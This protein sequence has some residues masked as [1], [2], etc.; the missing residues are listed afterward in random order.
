MV[1]KLYEAFMYVIK[2]ELK[3]SIR[4]YVILGAFDGILLGLSILLAGVISHIS[5]DSISISIY[6]GIVATA[7][8][9][10]W[11]ALVVELGEKKTELERMEK[12]VLKSLRGTIY[13]YSGKIASVLAAIA[14]GL[15]PFL[16]LTVLYMYEYSH[17]TFLSL[18][19]GLA[20]LGILGLLYGEGIK[21]KIYTMIQLIVAGIVTA[22]I[23]LLIIR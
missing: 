1:N 21:N 15:S 12:Q 6:S 19:V 2:Y 22:F 10:T 8:S 5:L 16:G 3:Q 9:S 13:D 11:N 14:H 23:T 4:R 7:I 18:C 17:S 20:S